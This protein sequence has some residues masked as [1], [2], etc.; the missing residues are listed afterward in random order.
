MSWKQVLAAAVAALGIGAAS[1][2][3]APS[4]ATDWA[5]FGRF[6]SLMQVFMQAACPPG[7]AASQGCDPNAAQKAF[8]DIA[9]GRNPEANALMLE[10]FA[11]VPAPERE[12]MLAIGRSMMA[13]NH[14][15]MTAEAQAT[16]DVSAIRA[17]KDLTTMGLVYHDRT[18]FL[19]AV[20][21]R[22]AIA[23][24]LFL[25]GRGVDPNAKD[26]WGMSAL[27]LARRGG[28]PEIITLLSAVAPR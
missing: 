25:A 17:R 13:M 3:S 2:Q 18:Q 12:K 22:D 8:D 4:P 10:I 23:V 16:T 19:D 14:K 6:L 15:Q 9:S 28:D 26:P 24:R 1:A 7:G 27:E 20:K 21:R 5:T 11:G